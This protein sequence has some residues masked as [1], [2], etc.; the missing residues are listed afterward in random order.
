[1]TTQEFSY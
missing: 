1:M